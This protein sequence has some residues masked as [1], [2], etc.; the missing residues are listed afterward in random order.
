MSAT[1][2]GSRPRPSACRRARSPRISWSPLARDRFAEVE[3]RRCRRR[4]HEDVAVLIGRRLGPALDPDARRAAPDLPPDLLV[5]RLR[6]GAERTQL[7]LAP[8]EL[9]DG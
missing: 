1:P 7:E 8:H 4:Q 2:R 9:V 5:E 3:P 6:A